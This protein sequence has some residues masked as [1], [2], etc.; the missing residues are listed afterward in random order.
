MKT[1][2]TAPRIVFA[3][4]LLVLIVPHAN[5][6]VTAQPPVAAP[7]PP[8]GPAATP[9]PEFVPPSPALAFSATP[10]APAIP[11]QTPAYP[12]APRQTPASPRAAA[13]IFPSLESIQNQAQLDKVILALDL[14]L[15]DT[16]NRCDLEAFSSFLADDVEFYHDQGGVTLGNANL[17]ESVKKNICGGDVRRELVPG[18]FQAN[19]MKGYGAVEL[20]VHRFVHPKSNNPTGEGRFVHL[21]QYKEGKW[22]VTR[23]ISYDHHQAAKEGAAN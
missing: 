18:T 13:Q 2:S 15:F 12:P 4:L 17:T 8:P 16:Y 21:W 5:A 14:A 9:P 19:Y 6:Q 3:L 1:L 7:A 20:G 22:K 10:P 23:A 11:P